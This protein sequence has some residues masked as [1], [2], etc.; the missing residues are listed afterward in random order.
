MTEI[1]CSVRKGL[2]H[3]IKC[4]YEE[5]TSAQMLLIL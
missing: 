4:K 2:R 1:L 5:T 3:N